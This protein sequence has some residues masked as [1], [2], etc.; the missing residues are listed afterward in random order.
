MDRKGGVSSRILSLF[1]R[2][3]NDFISTMLVENNIAL[4]I[5]GIL[6]A[7]TPDENLDIG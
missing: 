2:N 1:F 4:V 3:P 7:Q 6:M 5:Y